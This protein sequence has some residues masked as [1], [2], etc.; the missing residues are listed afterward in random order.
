MSN[1]MKFLIYKTAD[2][3]IRVNAILKDE[4]IWLTQKGMGE[5]F[6]CSSDN[7]SL[8]LKNIFNEGELDKN[9]VTEKISATRL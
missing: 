6:G 5:L 7:I 2:E 4:T 9:S 3:D 8:H 1:E